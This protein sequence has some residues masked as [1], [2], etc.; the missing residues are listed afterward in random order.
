MGGVQGWGDVFEGLPSLMMMMRVYPHVGGETAP[1]RIALA[2]DNGLSPSVPVQAQVF[3]M[4]LDHGEEGYTPES[5]FPGHGAS[6]IGRSSGN[7]A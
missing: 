4:A 5:V 7:L 1:S 2:W 6:I 3:H